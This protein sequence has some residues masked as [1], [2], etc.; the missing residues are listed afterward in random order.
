MNRQGYLLP[1]S[2]VDAGSWRATF[3]RETMT[4]GK[5]LA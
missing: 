1:L 4:A 2:N 3:S 5:G